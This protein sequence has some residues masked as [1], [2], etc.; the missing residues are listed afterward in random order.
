MWGGKEGGGKSKMKETLGRTQKT[1]N[2]LRPKSL[3]SNFT[4]VSSKYDRV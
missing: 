4:K 1:M 2:G 3:Q